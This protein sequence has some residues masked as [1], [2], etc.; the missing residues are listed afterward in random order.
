MS[1]S[2]LKLSQLTVRPAW[3]MP[4]SHR[5]EQ[6]LC[7]TLLLTPS[8]E[9]GCTKSGSSSHLHK[10]SRASEIVSTLLGSRLYTQSILVFLILLGSI[11]FLF[12]LACCLLDCGAPSPVWNMHMH[13]QGMRRSQLH[14]TKV[15]EEEK[16]S[17]M[18]LGGHRREREGDAKCWKMCYVWETEW[19]KESMWK[20]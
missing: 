15:S 17:K 16:E 2:Q 12:Y 19:G 10:G 18:N 13:R 4:K 11:C 20:D 9:E 1:G 5:I 3:H 7:F 14:F 6:L 8:W